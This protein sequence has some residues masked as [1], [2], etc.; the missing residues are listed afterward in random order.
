MLKSHQLKDYKVIKY[1]GTPITPI[2]VFEEHMVGKNVLIPFTDSR[3]IERAIKYCDKIII[4]NGAFSIWKRKI[5]IDWGSYYDW[6]Q[7]YKNRIEFYLIPDVI[8]G[9]EEENDALLADYFLRGETKGVPIW[10]VDE[11]FERLDRLV[12]W[13][14]YIAIGSSGDYDK[15]GTEKWHKRMNNAISY[16]INKDGIPKCKI[17]MLRCLNPRIFTLYPFESGDST[18]FAQNHKINGGVHFLRNLERY[19]SPSTYVV[20]KFYETECLFSG[21]V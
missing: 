15:L 19:K 5:K 11:S 9:T 4:D 17:H 2:T 20:K 7:Q 16:I 13:F 6:V 18:T 21:A 3:D 1:H 10:H 8:G 12:N 14:D